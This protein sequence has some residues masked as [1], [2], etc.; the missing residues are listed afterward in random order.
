MHCELV[1]SQ[2]AVNIHSVRRECG[3]ARSA[4]WHVLCNFT[5]LLWILLLPLSVFP[6]PA[7]PCAV[8]HIPRHQE[9]N[10]SRGTR[11]FSGVNYS[12]SDALCKRTRA[13]NEPRQLPIFVESE[14]SNKGI[15]YT[16]MK[17]ETS[18]TYLMFFYRFFFMQWNGD[19]GIEDSK[20]DARA[21][22][23]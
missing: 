9:R 15:V 14:R 2:T 10:M 13:L 1:P 3:S 22:Y 8:R 16:K 20:T 11:A 21:T 12:T 6:Q 18:F 4:Q 5:L 17:T 7:S 19:R 23:K